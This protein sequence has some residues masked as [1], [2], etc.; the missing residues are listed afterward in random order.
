MIPDRLLE[1]LRTSEN[2]E[3]SRFPPT[4]VFNEGWMLR[5]TLD[6]VQRLG[7]TGHPFSFH[8]QATWFSE[9]LLSSPFRPRQRPDDLAEGFTNADAVIGHFVFRPDTATGLR[10]LPDGRQFVVIEAKMFS[11]LSTRTTNAPAYDQAARNVACM[12]ETIRQSG[13]KVSEFDD[14]GF[15]VVAPAREQRGRPDTNLEAC[16]DPGSIKSAVRRRISRYEAKSRPEAKELK[17]W[18][19]SVFLPLVDRLVEM[20]RLA[21][22]SWEDCFEAIAKVD[23]KAGRE[24]GQFYRR[25][26]EFR[27]VRTNSGGAAHETDPGTRDRG[28]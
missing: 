6:A 24:L 14:L 3:T 7:L 15:L 27:P 17:E 5:L 16:M 10:L 4:E 20:R 8:A 11:N 18:E 1:L 26:L 28:G 13:K 21:V 22:L 19:E 12:A 9:A 25:C 23:T 2:T